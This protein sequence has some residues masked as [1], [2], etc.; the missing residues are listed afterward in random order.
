VGKMGF[1][2]MTLQRR[3][4]LKR[5]IVDDKEGCGGMTLVESNM[6]EAVGDLGAQN[7]G[8]EVLEACGML[9]VVVV[10]VAVEE[11]HVLK[12]AVVELER[13]SAL[14]NNIARSTFDSCK[15]RGYWW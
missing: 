15:Q 3:H 14:F 7:V 2:E 1:V 11:Q 10:V 8:S 9:V 13:L 4:M 12:G 6:A 5:L